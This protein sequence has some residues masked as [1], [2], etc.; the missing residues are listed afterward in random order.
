MDSA[1]WFAALSLAATFGGMLPYL[2]SALWGHTRPHPVT[3]AAWGVMAAI[4]SALPHQG[5]GRWAMACTALLCLMIAV[6]GLRR[7]SRGLSRAERLLLAGMLAALPA[8]L[9]SPDPLWAAVLITAID[10]A[11]FWPTLRKTWLQPRSENLIY[12]GS[13]LIKYPASLAAMESVTLANGIYPV[14][15]VAAAA[16]LLAV[17][18]GRRRPGDATR[19]RRQPATTVSV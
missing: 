8:W 13:W 11:A 9:F 6:C 5:A 15:N 2:A 7:Q 4:I 17:A 16:V 18:L 1:P 12:Y 19:R 10:L 14:A 3:W